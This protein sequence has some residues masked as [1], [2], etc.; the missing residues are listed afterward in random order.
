[1]PVLA[2]TAGRRWESR[3]SRPSSVVKARGCYVILHERKTSHPEAAR[4]G[5]VVFAKKCCRFKLCRSSLPLRY[6]RMTVPPCLEQRGRQRLP[7][8]GIFTNS[9]NGV[10]PILSIV[11]MSRWSRIPVCSTGS[12]TSRT[13]ATAFTLIFAV[14]GDRPA[15]LSERHLGLQYDGRVAAPPSVRRH[16]PYSRS[17]SAARPT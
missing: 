7:S 14:N 6:S 10:K 12:P 3:C 15:S 11:R 4:K 13:T 8:S 5:D 17:A 1:M 9:I 16:R 2:S